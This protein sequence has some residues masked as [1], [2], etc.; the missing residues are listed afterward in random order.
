MIAS[1]YKNQMGV[2]DPESYFGY[3]TVAQNFF[4]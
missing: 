3:L 4:L 2:M 1:K